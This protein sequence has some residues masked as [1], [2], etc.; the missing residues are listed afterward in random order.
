[1]KRKA[2][3]LLM[4]FLLKAPNAEK[5]KNTERQCLPSFELIWSQIEPTMRSKIKL[6]EVTSQEAATL[7]SLARSKKSPAE[8][9]RRAKLLVFLIENP[10]F[11]PA[12]AGYTVGFTSFEAGRRWVERFNQYGL[13]GL[14]DRAR[15]GRPPTHSAEVKNT[16]LALATVMPGT[17]GFP[18]QSWTLERLQQA[19]IQ[20]NGIYLSKGTIWKWIEGKGLKWR[21]QHK[22]VKLGPLQQEN[23]E[24]DFP[25]V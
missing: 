15:S 8:V 14:Q 5:N 9:V 7:R 24:T 1:M 18:Y 19:F 16:L 22:W 6:R 12:Q 20:H 3:A 2:S 13:E 10:E 21:E 23:T 4:N 17:M 11:T 25:R